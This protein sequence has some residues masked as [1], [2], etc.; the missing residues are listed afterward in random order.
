MTTCPNC[1]F[2]Q[3]SDGYG[4]DLGDLQLPAS[5]RAVLSRLIE[6]RGAWV[7]M[8]NMIDTLY[9]DRAD[10]G[11]DRANKTVQCHISKLRKRM[12]DTPWKVTNERFLGYRLVRKE[13]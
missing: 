3:S 5:E 7:S 2:R 8:E 13:A 4:S 10:G 9:G 12:S 6:A 1:G 11:P